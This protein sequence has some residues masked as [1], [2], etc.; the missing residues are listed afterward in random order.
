MNFVKRIFG[1][2]I[3]LQ[4]KKHVEQKPIT[5]IPQKPTNFVTKKSYPYTVTH[6]KPEDPGMDN[7]F[8]GCDRIESD[9]YHEDEFYL[10]NDDTKS[11][12]KITEEEH[13]ILFRIRN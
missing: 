12:D 3:S 13:K 5:V 9:E 11:Y 2:D 7:G 8:F 10:W 1:F 6:F 4:I